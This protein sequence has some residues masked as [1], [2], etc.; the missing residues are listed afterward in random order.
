MRRQPAGPMQEPPPDAADWLMGE[1]DYANAPRYG[2]PMRCCPQGDRRHYA[3][4]CGRASGPGAAFG[5]RCDATMPMPVGTPWTDAAREAID[6]TM[7]IRE[8]S[9]PTDATMSFR[10]ISQTA[11]GL[12]DVNA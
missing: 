10:V 3:D 7:P 1:R 6:V 4:A 8:V 9:Q 12:T 5:R 2:R 11:S